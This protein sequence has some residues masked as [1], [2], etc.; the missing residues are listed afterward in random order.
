[1]LVIDLGGMLWAWTVRLKPIIDAV[2]IDDQ[3]LVNFTGKIT[4]LSDMFNGLN[5]VLLG[6]TLAANGDLLKLEFL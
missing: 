2:R 1:M 6:V 5:F 3:K 4:T